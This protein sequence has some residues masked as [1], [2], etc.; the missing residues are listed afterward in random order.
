MPDV[1]ISLNSQLR[2]EI[3]LRHLGR[4]GGGL[5][6]YIGARYRR[7]RPVYKR[8]GAVQEFFAEGAYGLGVSGLIVRQGIKGLRH[9]SVTVCAVAVIITA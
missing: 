2:L 6:D 9:D 7:N 5:D 4:H 3:F 8:F 1:L